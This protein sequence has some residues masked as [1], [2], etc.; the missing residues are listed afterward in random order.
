MLLSGSRMSDRVTRRP[1]IER[2]RRV[3]AATV[4]TLALALA[5]AMA[6]PNLAQAV[7]PTVA[8]PSSPAS[9]AYRF[10][11]WELD[12]ADGARRYRVQLAVPRR[13]APA[14][15]FPVLYMLD[16]NAAFA[17]LTAD[18]LLALE[19][20]GMPPVIVAIGYATNLRF[21][22]TARA[23]DYT[24]PMP[25]P[26][27]TMDSG[28]HDRP[29]GGADIFL[30]LIEQ[31]IK[32][33]VRE[34]VAIDSARQSLWGH[35]YGGLFV[36]HALLRQPASFQR[37]IAADPSFW[38]QNGFILQEERQAAAVTPGACLLVMSGASAGNVNNANN[39]NNANPASAAAGQAPPPARAG[40]DPAAAQR[41][42]EA[43]RSVPPETARLFVARQAQR[44]GLRATW[45]EFEG[46][47]HGAMLGLSVGPALQ[48][49]S[50]APG[51]SCTLP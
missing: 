17:A 21:D 40:I 7:G 49:A 30:A 8:E 1:A 43:R 34:R 35:S 22:T 50:S 18:Q 41:M 3:A 11:Q 15:G 28:A 45:R 42:R 36:L 5:P 9:A 13:A 24:P 48:V 51:A 26:G 38:W 46:A 31:Q 10:E 19:R 2:G 39:A 16:G 47:S 25:G 29:A 20:D 33:A 32:P 44:D 27:P 37:Y 4:A 12:A 6:Q 23:Y 14:G